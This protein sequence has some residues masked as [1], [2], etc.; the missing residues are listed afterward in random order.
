MRQS[1]QIALAAQQ[2]DRMQVFTDIV[3]AFTEAGIQYGQNF[4]DGNIYLFGFKTA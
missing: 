2:T 1:Q 3:N 4:D